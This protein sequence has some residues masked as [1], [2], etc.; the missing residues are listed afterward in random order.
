M[1][2]TVENLTPNDA[3]EVRALGLQT[4]ELHLNASQ[5]IYYEE[6]D[7]RSL[8]TSP[9]DIYLAA[10]SEGELAG[11][12]IGTFNPYLKEAYMIDLVV[13]PEFRGQGVATAL[14]QQAFK[15]LKE[16]GAGWAWGLVHE[17]NAAMMQIL[18]KKGFTRGRKFSVYFT[19]IN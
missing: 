18:E 15:L 9:T 3:P 16:R 6:E 12:F 8:F 14:F 10:R 7:L 19:G 1:S 13:K 11:Y 4:P 2:F 17:D 5:P